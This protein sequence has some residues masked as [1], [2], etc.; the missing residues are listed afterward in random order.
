[1]SLLVDNQLP[2]ALARHL[3]ANGLEC[4]HVQ[5]VGLDNADDRAIWMYAKERNLNRTSRN[6]KFQLEALSK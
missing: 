4:I 6:P 1:M 5:D 3:T 2:V